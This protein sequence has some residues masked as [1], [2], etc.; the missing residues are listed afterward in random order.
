MRP[1]TKLPVLVT[2]LGLAACA[3][4]PQ[5]VAQSPADAGEAAAAMDMSAMDMSAHQEMLTKV[6]VYKS[7]LCGCCES[8]VEHMRKAGFEVEVVNTDDLDAIKTR[9]GVPAGMGSCHTAEV[10]GYFIEGH[11]PASDVSRLLVERPDVRG[12]AVPGMVVGSPGMEQGDAV[13]PYDVVAVAKDGSTSVF[14]H[15][16]T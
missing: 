7:Q 1:I 6:V 9:V 11:V 4:E 13:E 3:P 10:D 16:G 8:W 12:L 2:M 5:A 14:A 15:H